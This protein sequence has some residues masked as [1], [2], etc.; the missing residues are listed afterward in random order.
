MRRILILGAGLVVKPL[1]DD[2]LELP[3]VELRL[4]TLNIGRAHALIAGRPRAT[5]V[6][7]DAS[8][9]ADLR[10]E[11]SQAKVVVSLL[12]ADRHAGIAR[13]CLEQGV[14]L[15]TTSYVSDAMQ[16]LDA[17]ARERG[18]LL[19]NEIGLDPGIDHMTAIT[20]I[21]SIQAEGGRV[22]SF[23]SCCGAIPAP[24]SNDNPWGY[25]FAWSPRGVVLAARNPVRYLEQGAV[26]ERPFPDLFD[27]PRSIEIPGVGRLEAYPNRNCLRYLDAYGVPGVRDFFRGT[28]RYPGWCQTWHALFDL[29]LLGLE[30]EDV[31]NLTYAEF[32]D[33][34]LPPGSGSLSERLAQ[35]LGVAQGH[36]VLARLEWL[37]LL[38]GRPVPDGRDAPLDVLT[39]ILQERLRYAP[40]EHD[41]VALEHRCLAVYGN[42]SARQIS[43][44]LVVR[45]EA[46][47]DSAL[48][49]TVSLPAAVACRLLLEGR[50]PIPGVQIPL[51][52]RITVPVLEALRERGI[53]ADQTV[54]EVPWP[55]STPRATG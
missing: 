48:A 39:R 17:R 30:P 2:L 41:L 47:D 11:I 7:A 28:L 45:G 31:S 32:L 52:P 25:K 40:G 34:H 21:R 35:R 46:G 36:P 29:G 1:V 16:A 4:L 38:S 49:R 22:V 20:L 5:A 18:V 12:P 3:E 44:R 26:I 53:V 27:D 50:I 33:R 6:E 43:V 37:G 24:D 23:S 51:D 9:E 10:A 8:A 42:G 15:V 55:A 19:L 54:E 13:V 14:P